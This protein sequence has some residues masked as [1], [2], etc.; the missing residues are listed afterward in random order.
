[1]AALGILHGRSLDETV[2]L[3]ILSFLK[4]RHGESD[5]EE[6]LLL[7]LSSISNNSCELLIPRFRLSLKPFVHIDHI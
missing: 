2:E 1:M 5:L 4:R 7:I 6:E 3:G